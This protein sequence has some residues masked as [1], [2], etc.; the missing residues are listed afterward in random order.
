MTT[1]A[2][3]AANDQKSIASAMVTSP[4]SQRAVRLWTEMRVLT[5]HQVP[6]N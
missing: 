4:S 6:P 2:A 5:D 3:L 1:F